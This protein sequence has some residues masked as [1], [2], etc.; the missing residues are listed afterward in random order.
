MIT[1][2]VSSPVNATPKAGGFKSAFFVATSNNFSSI[3]LFVLN[4]SSMGLKFL[5]T[6]SQKNLSVPCCEPDDG[7]SIGSTVQPRFNP[8]S[9]SSVD[10]VSM[11]NWAPPSGILVTSS[12]C[13]IFDCSLDNSLTLVKE[14]S[15]SMFFDNF[16]ISILFKI[17]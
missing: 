6:T 11:G 5:L 4:T 13:E 9:I 16:F 14:S 17:K 3:R 10:S 15:S 12:Y 7:I 8:R 2:Q 1:N